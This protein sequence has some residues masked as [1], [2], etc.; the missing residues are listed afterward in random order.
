M[1][2]SDEGHVGSRCRAQPAV[3]PS[4]QS[5]DPLTVN[6]ASPRHHFFLTIMKCQRL[7]QDPDWKKKRIAHV[8]SWIKLSSNINT[9]FSWYSIVL[10]SLLLGVFHL[11]L[12]KLGKDGGSKIYSAYLNH[13]HHLYQERGQHIS[14]QTSQPSQPHLFLTTLLSIAKQTRRNYVVRR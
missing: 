1:L 5:R 4:M 2:T 13:S 11:H 9:R 14:H 6:L 7:S 10:P 8:V 12:A 3:D